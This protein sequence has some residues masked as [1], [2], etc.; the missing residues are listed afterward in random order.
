MAAV[1]AARR[2]RPTTARGPRYGVVG[3]VLFHGLIFAA[4]L[5]TFHRNLETPQD[6]HIVP[7]ELVTIADQ[8]NVATQAP[9]PEKMERP[10]P[11]IEPPP[12]PQLQEVEPAP[13]PPVPKFDIA[14]EKPKPVEPPKPNFDDLL[15]K[16]TA[17]EKPVKNAKAAPRAIPGVGNSNLMTADL[18][19]SLR[20][21]IYRCWSPPV[22]APNAND[23]VVNFDLT[24]SPDGRPL[25]ATSDDLT[26]GNGFTKAAAEAA[27]RA[28]YQCAPYRLPPERYG[29]WREISPLRFDPR[30]MM[31]R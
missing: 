14:K 12:E 8:T 4:A 5:F 25:T 28:I 2:L 9:E 6:S 26:S 19:D 31:E 7:V 3:S 15:N 16:L 23:L 21:Q 22:G 13:I 1:A 17:P 30:Q 18:A 11:V 24:L 20:S 29:Q 10:E 27:R